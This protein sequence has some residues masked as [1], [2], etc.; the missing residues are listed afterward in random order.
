M[1]VHLPE[2]HLFESVLWQLHGSDLCC[3]VSGLLVADMDSRFTRTDMLE[4]YIPTPADH[5]SEVSRM[6]IPS[7]DLHV[8]CYLSKTLLVTTSATAK[9]S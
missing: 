2:R 9:R 5:D 4:L 3:T 1:L 7:G 8:K 6:P